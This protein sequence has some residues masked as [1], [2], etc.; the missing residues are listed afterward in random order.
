MLVA[1]EAEVARLDQFQPLRLVNAGLGEF[2]YAVRNHQ[3]WHRERFAGQLFVE[4]VQVVFIHVGI[5]NEVGEPARRVAGQ[6][7]NQVKR[8]A[9]IFIHLYFSTIRLHR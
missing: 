5:A 1:F 7:A 9:Q 4:H 3:F 8:R 2:R 6:A